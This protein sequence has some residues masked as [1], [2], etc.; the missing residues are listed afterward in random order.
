MIL[1][2]LGFQKKSSRPASRLSYC[3]TKMRSFR[4]FLCLFVA[5]RLRS[6]PATDQYVGLTRLPEQVRIRV[7]WRGAHF[8]T[9][10]TA[11]SSHL[12]PVMFVTAKIKRMGV[13]AVDDRPIKARVIP[14]P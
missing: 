3:S 2:L 12:P 1:S 13:T 9:S 6:M 8:S 4:V 5:I 7:H 11:I 14:G 10:T